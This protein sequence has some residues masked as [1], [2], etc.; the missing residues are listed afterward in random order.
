VKRDDRAEL[1]IAYMKSLPAQQQSVLLLVLWLNAALT[2][3][4]QGVQLIVVVRVLWRATAAAIRFR[5]SVVLLFRRAWRQSSASPRSTSSRTNTWPVNSISGLA[6]PER[7]SPP[8]HDSCNVADP[9]T[10]LWLLL[11]SPADPQ[12]QSIGTEFGGRRAC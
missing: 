5:R 11:R 12:R 2:L 8:P 9:A 10:S 7:Q 1:G 3:V 4:L 6:R